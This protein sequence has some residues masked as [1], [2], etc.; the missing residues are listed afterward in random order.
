LI[1]E[2]DFE[3]LMDAVTIACIG[4]ITAETAQS[5]GFRVHVIAETYTIPGLTD[6]L[7]QYYRDIRR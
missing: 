3:K 2:E 1:P 7:I 5:M 4:P 6:A